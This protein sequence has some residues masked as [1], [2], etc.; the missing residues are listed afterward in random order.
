MGRFVSLG[1]SAFLFSYSHMSAVDINRNMSLDVDIAMTFQHTSKLN[2]PTCGSR[3]LLKS[4]TP[5]KQAEKPNLHQD[6]LFVPSLRNSVNA[7]T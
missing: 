3:R 6:Q 7:S 1:K 2:R 4:W 5:L